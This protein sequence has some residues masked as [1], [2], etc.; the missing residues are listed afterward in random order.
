MEKCALLEMKRGTLETV[1]GPNQEEMRAL[2]E[3]DT[4]KY[5]SVLEVDTLKSTEMKEK[6]RNEYLSRTRKLFEIKL[7]SRY[8][9]KGITTEAIS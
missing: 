2:D 6:I 8:L 4:Y 5:M 9:I 3:H 7:F 1:G